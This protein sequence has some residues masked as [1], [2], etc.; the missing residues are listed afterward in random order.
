MIFVILI[1]CLL[2]KRNCKEKFH[3]DSYTQVE[4]LK[5][6]M[7]AVSGEVQAREQG[8]EQLK[9]IDRKLS[10]HQGCNKEDVQG[11][12]EE[13]TSTERTLFLKEQEK[14]DLIEALLRLKD[15]LSVPESANPVRISQ[16]LTLQYMY[17]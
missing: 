17:M 8:Y 10:S 13:I 14:N 16:D 5:G 3:V 12:V 15:K 7:D 4:V 2:A 6:E 9:N 1:T 11:L